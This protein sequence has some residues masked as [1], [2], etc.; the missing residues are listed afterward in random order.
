MSSSDPVTVV[1]QLATRAGRAPA[2]RW[3]ADWVRAAGAAGPV[4]VRL[5]GYRESSRLN[6]D[7]RGKIGS[8]NV[9]SFPAKGAPGEPELGDLVICLPLV[10]REARE[11]RKRPFNHLA[12]LVVHG[13]LHL[14]GYDHEDPREARKME[15]AEV[16][17]LGRLGIDNPYRSRGPVAKAQDS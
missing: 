6:G 4:T 13:T 7:F 15:R 11:Q 17:I 1:V 5:V 9:L 8:T 10:Y 2:A 3:L 16:R 12:H 14:R